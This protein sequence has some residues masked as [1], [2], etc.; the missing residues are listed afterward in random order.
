MKNRMVIPHA[1]YLRAPKT[2]KEIMGD[3]C[4]SLVPVLLGTVYFWGVRALLLTAVSVFFCVLTE[5]LWEVLW[6]RQ[7][8]IGDYSAV[9]TGLLLAFNMPVTVPWWVLALAAVFS[10]GVVK[11]MFGGIG[12]NVVNPALMGRLFVMILWPASVM[13]YVL[14]GTAPVDSVSSATV[15]S[16]IKNGQ[17][18]VFSY[19]QMFLGDIPG[20]MGETCKLLL[21]VGFAYMCYKGVVNYRAAAAYLLTAVAILFV[22]GGPDGLFT[23]DILG[24]LLSG[25][26]LLGAFYMLTDY[27]F[28]SRG[29]RILYGVAA[30]AATALIRIYSRYPEGVCF[31]ILLANCLAGLLAEYY[32]KKHR[33]YGVRR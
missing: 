31:G 8:T 19:W 30:G 16:F 15:L 25:G 17:K 23:G 24:H 29:G 6:R 21:V 26:L 22:L 27:V 13:R 32:K 9:V 11:Q 14:P 10:I 5:Y 12:N 20:S 28:V 33:V 4:L 1:P 2:T 7:V 18:P 3:V